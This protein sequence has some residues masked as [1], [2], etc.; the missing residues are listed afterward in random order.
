MNKNEELYWMIFN[1]Q[2][3][4]DCAKRDLLTWMETSMGVVPV[5]TNPAPAP[6]P[7]AVEDD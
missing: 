6:D 7:A 3:V 4:P 5:Q 2:D 1:R